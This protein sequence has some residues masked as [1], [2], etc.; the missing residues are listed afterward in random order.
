[1]LGKEEVGVEGRDGDVL[2]GQSAD[3]EKLQ[4]GMRRDQ[5]VAV[6]ESQD[7]IVWRKLIKVQP[8]CFM[9]KKTEHPR[10]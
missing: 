3:E 6:M 7:F 2:Q 5:T 4:K 1:M 8:S 9:D 10:V